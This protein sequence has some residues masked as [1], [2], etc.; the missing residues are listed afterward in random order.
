MQIMISGKVLINSD[1]PS[2]I[3]KILFGVWPLIADFLQIVCSM[4]FLKIF[5]INDGGSRD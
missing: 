2:L 1:N 3:N 5:T 4:G